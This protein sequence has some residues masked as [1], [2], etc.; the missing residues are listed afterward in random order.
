MF[1]V[2]CINFQQQLV[3]LEDMV[4]QIIWLIVL[5]KGCK[6]L[7]AECLETVREF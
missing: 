6:F 2:N 1:Q 4:W 7:G 3:K 5:Q